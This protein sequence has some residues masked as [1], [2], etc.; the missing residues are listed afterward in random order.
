MCRPLGGATI[1]TTGNVTVAPPARPRPHPPT[2]M[3]DSEPEQQG[4]DSATAAQSMIDAVIEAS[5]GGGEGPDIDPEQYAAWVAQ[6]QQAINEGGDSAGLCRACNPRATMHLCIWPS[7]SHY[8]GPC[9][10]DAE[11]GRDC[12]RARH[13]RRLCRRRRGQHRRACRP[14]ADGRRGVWRRRI[15]LR[16]PR[17]F[18]CPPACPLPPTDC[19]LC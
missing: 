8:G 17:C 19:S 14:I 18:A 15:A 1:E 13:C 10:L 7:F 16:S 2:A 3:A 6:I 12:H 11:D 4:L 9:R 5:A